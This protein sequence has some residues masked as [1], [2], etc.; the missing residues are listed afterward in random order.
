M[1]R[2][3]QKFQTASPNSVKCFIKE[4]RDQTYILINKHIYENI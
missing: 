4:E 3:A 1:F 2:F